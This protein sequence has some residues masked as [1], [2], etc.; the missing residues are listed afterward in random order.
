MSDPAMDVGDNE[1]IVE[2][3][4]L[5]QDS[6]NAQKDEAMRVG[7]SGPTNRRWGGDNLRRR[8]YN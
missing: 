4:P 3:E 8:N 1:Q 7:W 5:Q 6:A 2:Y